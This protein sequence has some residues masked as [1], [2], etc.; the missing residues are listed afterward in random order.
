MNKV[1]SL[2]IHVPFCHKICDYCDF[3]KLQ[4]FRNFAVKYLDA[5]EEE[6]KAYQI[7]DLK[8]I[9]VGGGTPTA[10]EDD[11]FEELLKIIDPYVNGVEEYTFEANP[12]SLSLDKIK[13]LKS[14]GVN[15]VSIGVQTTDDKILNMVNR[16]H[17]FEQVKTAIKSLKETGIDNIN[18]DLILGLPHSSETILRKDLE[19]IL[20]LNIK[21]ISCYGLTVNPHTVLFN[22]GYKEPEG[23]LL[24]AFYD[25]VEEELTKN[26]FV[27]YEVSNWAKPGYQS[28]HNLT[29]WRNEEYFGCGLGASGYIGETRYKNTVNLSQYIDRVFVNEKELVSEK[30]KRTYQIMLNLRT[31]EGLD[32]SFVKDKQEEIDSLISSG[33]LIKKDHKL[34]PTYEGMMVLD[35]ILLKLI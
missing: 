11:L 12:E 2:Y 33:L 18:V 20:S 16:D 10:L 13:M 9:Y 19:N 30:D 1:K 14:H 24:R 28:E 15:R 17:T 25:T 23:D 29:Y 26:G 4:Y 8:T 3:T 35:Q 22:K 7:K 32:I 21:H 5:L 27:H 31:I 6:L 34:I